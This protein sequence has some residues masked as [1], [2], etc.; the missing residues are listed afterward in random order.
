[1]RKINLLGLGLLLLLFMSTSCSADEKSNR[2]SG[3]GRA[4]PG[5]PPAS[6]QIDGRTREF[7]SVVPESY[8]PSVAH[9]L[10]FAFHG[11]TTPNAR[12]RK[13]Y[14]LEQNSKMPTIFVYPASPALRSPGSE[15][16]MLRPA[17]HTESGGLVPPHQRPQSP[18][19]ILS[20]PLAQRGGCGDHGVL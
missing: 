2:S 1:M 5:V 20:P 16:R 13:Y 12:V 14:R 17:R 7:I 19:K 6:I 3:C 18:G 4:A 9:R 15:V 11:R 8:D 10:I